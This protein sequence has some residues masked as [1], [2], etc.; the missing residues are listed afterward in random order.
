M[1]ALTFLGAAIGGALA[2]FV[3]AFFLVFA[4]SVT[5]KE[6]G[7]LQTDLWL[8]I[9]TAIALSLLGAMGGIYIWWKQWQTPPT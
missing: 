7:T 8:A 2:G 6:I 5:V 4:C 1:K 3:L 9:G